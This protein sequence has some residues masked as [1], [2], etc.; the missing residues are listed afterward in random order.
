MYVNYIMLSFFVLCVPFVNN[1]CIFNYSSCASAIWS[2]DGNIW[3]ENKVFRADNATCWSIHLAGYRELLRGGFRDWWPI[4]FPPEVYAQTWQ[5]YITHV[6]HVVLHCLVFTSYIWIISCHHVY[7]HNIYLNYGMATHL[8]KT[9]YS[10]ITSSCLVFTII[11]FWIM[12]FYPWMYVN[13]G[14]PTYLINTLCSYVM[15]SCLHSLIFW[16]MSFHLF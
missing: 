9:S 5:G 10:Y 3:S 14:M 12:A 6:M 16:T 15:S 4:L 2:G 11:I 8:I 13:Y 1:I 7:I